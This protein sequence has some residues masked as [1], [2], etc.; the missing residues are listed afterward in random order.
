M[1]KLKLFNLAFQFTFFRVSRI[2]LPAATAYG[3]IGPIVPLTGWH[4][5]YIGFHGFPLR[6]TKWK[7]KEVK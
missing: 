1:S 5:R 2:D 3:L 4:S 7:K 6:L